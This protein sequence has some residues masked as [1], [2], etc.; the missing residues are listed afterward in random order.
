MRNLGSIELETKRLFL[1]RFVVEDA[2]AMF[3]NWAS[4]SENVRYVTWDPHPNPQVTQASI[5]RWLLHYQEEN[6]YKW[7]ICKKEDPKQV[8]GDISVVS[9]DPQKEICEVGYIL[10][11]NF[12]GQ[13]IMTEALKAVLHFLLLE[14]GFKEVQAKYVSLN[15]ASGRV[16]EKAGMHYLT[17]LPNAVD[18]KGYIGDQIT[19]TIHSSNL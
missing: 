15:P 5:E 9:Q 17:T 8:I 11:K 10:G 7:A 2:K 3:E 16:M 6:T 1:R 19:Y 18:R 12:W 13:G 4:D 14:V